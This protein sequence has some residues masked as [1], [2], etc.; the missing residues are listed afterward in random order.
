MS[1]LPPPLPSSS[2]PVNKYKTFARTSWLTLVISFAVNGVLIAGG[3]QY[4]SAFSRNIVAVLVCAL[5]LIGV[6]SGIAA[7]FGIR[8]HGRKKILW[9]A[10]IGVSI[11]LLLPA[12]AAPAFLK[13]RRLALQKRA[14]FL[15]VRH[16][17]GSTRVNDA[18]LGFSFEVPE[19]YKSS[20]KPPQGFRHAYVK[21]GGAAGNDVLGVKPLGG[22]LPHARLKAEN[23]P[24]NNSAKLI[25]LSWRG[26]DINASQVLETL[27]TGNYL[28]FNAQIPL[29]TQAIQLMLVGP[30]QR[31]Q[32][33]RETMEQVLDS[34]DGET[35]W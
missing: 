25:P 13:A 4:Q 22:K 16:T 21:S 14:A 33:L 34:L 23:L 2:E 35:N 29:R 9:P 7:F 24:L 12:L 30:A 31:E 19:G 18:E 15:P 10:L 1:T 17:P 11:W 28:T 27:S 26:L 5:F 20:F 3:P 32:Q 8:R 6:I